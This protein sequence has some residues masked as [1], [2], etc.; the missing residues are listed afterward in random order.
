MNP[1]ERTAGR[2]THLVPPLEEATPCPDL[3]LVAG[4]ATM[5]IPRLAP[6]AP[7]E[8]TEVLV[9]TKTLNSP[10]LIRLVLLLFLF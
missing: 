9:P 1:S 8:A 4:V 3:D 5:Y 6:W 10:S 7:Q 2:S